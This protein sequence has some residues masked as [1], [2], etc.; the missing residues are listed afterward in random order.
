MAKDMPSFTRQDRPKKVKDIYRALK[1]DHPTMPAEMK[2]RIAARQGKPGSQ[3]QGPPY[4]G[5][6]KPWKEKKSAIMDKY[7]MLKKAKA[8]MRVSGVEEHLGV[9]LDKKEERAARK[10]LKKS[11][12]RSFVLRHPWLTGIPTL[13]IAPAVAKDAAYR[14]AARRM[15]RNRPSLRKRVERAKETAHRREIEME[16][17]TAPRRVAR[18]AA[19]GAVGV[20]DRLS[21][22]GKRSND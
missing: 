10:R 5:P 6:V 16:R 19:A 12:D 14:K 9:G 22:M 4:K 11:R 18:E 7:D 15:L 21:R 20:A 8:R 3:K 2:A 13:G 17:A 1:R